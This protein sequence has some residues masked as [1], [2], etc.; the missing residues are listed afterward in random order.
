ML[1]DL[2]KCFD[3]LRISSGHD[4]LVGVDVLQSLGSNVGGTAV[5]ALKFK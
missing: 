5:N 1:A 4:D 3:S 2:Q